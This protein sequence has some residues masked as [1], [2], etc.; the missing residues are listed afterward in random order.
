MPIA[1]ALPYIA[2]AA[3]VAGTVSTINANKKAAA[4]AQAGV[5]RQ[6]AVASDVRYTPINVD[7]LRADATAQAIQN[8]TN[9][10]A[11]E[12]SLQPDLAATRENLARSVN[13]ELAQGGNLPPD[14]ANRVASEARTVNAASG[15]QGNAAPITASMIGL[16][17][18]DLLRQRQNSAANL[19]ASNPL[20][21]TGLDPGTLASVEVAENA[22]QNQFNLEKAGVASNLARSQTGADAAKIAAD[23]SVVPAVASGLSSIASLFRQQPQATNYGNLISKTTPPASLARTGTAFATPLPRYSVG[24]VS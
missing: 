7:K 2:T 18:L 4:A 11:L 3:S 13:N 10:L 24:P 14:V 19:L 8:A 17:S 6:S 22:A 23:A 9:S 15:A 20:Q 12:R 1:A 21:P 16:S 5:D